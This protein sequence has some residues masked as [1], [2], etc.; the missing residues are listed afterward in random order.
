MLKHA[1]PSI[2]L[3][4]C[5][6]CL[7]IWECGFASGSHICPNQ[8]NVSQIKIRST[9]PIAL[10]PSPRLPLSPSKD[11]LILSPLLHSPQL[12]LALS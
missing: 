3:S 11:C 5:L 2:L 8:N 1:C 9:A 7:Y 6:K 12:G 10:F 4:A